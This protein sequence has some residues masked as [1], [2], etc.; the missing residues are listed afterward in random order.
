[1]RNFKAALATV[2]LCLC[3]GGIAIADVYYYLYEYTINTDNA[4]IIIE[5]ETNNPSSPGAEFTAVTA[6]QLHQKGYQ[7]PSE[8]EASAD[9]IDKDG[10]IDWTASS[11]INKGYKNGNATKWVVCG[12]RTGRNFLQGPGTLF[13]ACSTF[14]ISYSPPPPHRALAFTKEHPTY[15]YYT[16]LTFY[17][18]YSATKGYGWEQKGRHHIGNP[19]DMRYTRA[20]VYW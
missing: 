13:V 19:N 1:M 5:V 7:T 12:S 16:N 18:E 8:Y 2:A 6:E 3:F 10:F 4:A 11:W 14:S 20:Y 9:V 15:G 17:H